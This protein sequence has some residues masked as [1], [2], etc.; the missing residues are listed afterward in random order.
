MAKNIY[1]IPASIDRSF[2]DHKISIAKG[3]AMAPIPLK[4]IGHYVLSFFL[5]L[6]LIMQTPIGHHVI[7]AILFSIWYLIVV[8]FFGR[9]TKTKEM[10]FMELRGLYKYY[11]SGSRKVMTRDGSKPYAFMS[12]TGIKNIEDNGIIHYLDGSVGQM[13]SVVGSASALLF[14][15]DRIGI[16]DRVD[17][18]WRK[19]DT[20]SEW[21]FMTTKEPQRVYRQVANLD[22]RNRNLK[23]RD[24]ELRELMKNQYDILVNFVGGGSGDSQFSAIHQYLIIKSKNVNQLTDSHSVLASEVENSTYMFKQCSILNGEETVEALKVLYQG[25]RV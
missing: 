18:F 10:K 14:D 19:V 25:R 13:Y 21:I 6:I 15:Q 1:K 3:G 9:I 8:F 5:W 20:D 2:L 24:P 12:I 4:L 7:I 16:I 23:F 17:A 22:N 11:I